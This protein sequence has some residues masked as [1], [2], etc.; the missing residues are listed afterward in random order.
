M[1]FHI[2]DTPNLGAIQST[3]R[4]GQEAGLIADASLTTDEATVL[5]AIETLAAG[6]HISFTP[7]KLAVKEAASAA[8]DFA[9]SE[10]VGGSLAAV[11][12]KLPDSGASWQPGFGHAY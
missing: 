4:Q 2:A 10:M 8:F 11:Y 5:A 7:L 3:L 6:L 12:A 9:P 1:A